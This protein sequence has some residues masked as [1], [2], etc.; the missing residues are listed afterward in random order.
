MKARYIPLRPDEKTE[1]PGIPMRSRAM[2]GRVPAR[3]FKLGVNVQ[4]YVP[5]SL[6]VQFDAPSPA[7]RLSQVQRFS[8]SVAKLKSLYRR[9]R[10]TNVDHSNA[11]QTPTP[12][13]GRSAGDE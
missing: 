10:G 6:S 8:N 3:M 4:S 5:F 2:T 7:L 1:I 13:D 11:A 12:G 9:D